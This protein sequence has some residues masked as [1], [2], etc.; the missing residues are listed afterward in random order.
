M[1]HL[2][3]MLAGTGDGNIT[4]RIRRKHTSTTSNTTALMST[5]TTLPSTLPARGLTPKNGLTCSLMLV[6]S[7]LCLLPVSCTKPPPW[8]MEMLMMYS[9]EH[10]DG[11]ALFNFSESV[12]KRSSV[13]LGPKRD[14]IG[15]LFAA[16]KEHQPHL[17]RGKQTYNLHHRPRS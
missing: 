1:P 15:E 4:P 7:T 11:Y 16:G 2:L 10:H 6:H 17:R 13:H 14:F 9:A 3:L 8:E 5:T 12:S